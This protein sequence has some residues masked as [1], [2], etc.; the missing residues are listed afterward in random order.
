MYRQEH[1]QGK[2]AACPTP[3]VTFPTVSSGLRGSRLLWAETCPPKVHMLKPEAPGSQ[4]VTTF[5]DTAFKEL[6]MLKRSH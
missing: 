5:G 3:R 4:D 6:I 1:H 2:T